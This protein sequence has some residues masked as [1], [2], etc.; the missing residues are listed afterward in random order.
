MIN[1]KQYK[2]ENNTLTPEVLQHFI[3]K[4]WHEVFSKL[5]HKN[6]Y[7]NLLVKVRYDSNDMGYAS[8]A[9]L[10][11]VGYEDKNLFT[12]YICDN[13]ALLT[14]T[15][16]STS[17]LRLDFS[18]MIKRGEIN[19]IDRS[20]LELRKVNPL[21]DTPKHSIKKSFLPFS[22]DPKEFGEILREAVTLGGN[23]LFTIKG[24]REEI[25]E[26]E[27]LSGG[28]V[29]KGTIIGGRGGN[30]QFSWEDRKQEGGFIRSDGGKQSWQYYDGGLVS[31]KKVP[32]KP[33][34]SLEKDKRINNKFVC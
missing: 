33:F 6:S 5:N 11:K 25:F 16:T 18:Y 8:L 13:L 2:I 1:I 26:I 17:V 15:Y 3:A 28:L 30:A 27:V 22:M 32:S 10:R 20:F 9:K 19:S 23:P 14:D 34:I 12:D 4:F 31:Y 29:N 24:A 7:L 21:T